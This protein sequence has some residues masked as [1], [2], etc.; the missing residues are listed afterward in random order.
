MRGFSSPERMIP[1]SAVAVSRSSDERPE[2]STIRMPATGIRAAFIS[3]STTRAPR[4]LVPTRPSRVPR[5]FSTI[6]AVK[7]SLSR[8]IARAILERRTEWSL[9]RS[10]AVAGVVPSPG[11]PSTAT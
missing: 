3:S 4:A 2:P 1:T 5:C 8:F 9:A 10:S 6:S 7:L 11:G